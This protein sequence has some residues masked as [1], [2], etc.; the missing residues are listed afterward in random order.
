LSGSHPKAPG[1]A[2]GYLLSK[3]AQETIKEWIEKKTH[4]RFLLT[5]NHVSK[6][7]PA[8][9]S[10]FNEIDFNVSDKSKDAMIEDTVSR[11]EK[12]L[13]AAGYERD[14]ASIRECVSEHYP[15][16]RKVANDLH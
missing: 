4:V 6:L 14:E 9:K 7:D 13:T 16:Y 3:E 11:F 15:D 2:G 12:K 5:T 8:L 1:F 10:R